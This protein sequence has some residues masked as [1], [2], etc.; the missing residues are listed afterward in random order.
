MTQGMPIPHPTR[1]SPHLT[2]MRLMNMP[3][4]TQT[5][6]HYALPHTM[7]SSMG[8]TTSQPT[9]TPP[10]PSS[11]TISVSYSVTMETE[12][13][14]SLPMCKPSKLTQMSAQWKRR[15]SDTTRSRLPMTIS[16]CFVVIIKMSSQRP[17]NT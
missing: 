11:T 9:Q 13:W 5:L 3:Q 14:G 12:S 17:S 8:L 7:M 4:T 1:S 6:P 16:T 2:V 10:Y 15:S